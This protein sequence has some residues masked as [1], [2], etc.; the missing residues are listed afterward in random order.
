MLIEF[1][2]LE[3]TVSGHS[4]E[5][6][7]FEAIARLPVDISAALAYLNATLPEAV[8]FRDDA[9]LSWRHEGSKIGFWTDRIAVDDLESREQAEQKMQYLVT[10]VNQTWK[11]RKEI[12][13]DETRHQ[14][15]QPLA[16]FKLLPATNCRKCGES[17]CFTFALKVASGQK[18]LKACLPLFSDPDLAERRERLEALVSGRHPALPSSEESRA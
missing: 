3:I 16:V 6:F 12:T 17:S 18:R 15:V 4:A 9:V 2:E 8:Y 7:E 10:L 13:P 5:H 14:R 11:R 1:Y